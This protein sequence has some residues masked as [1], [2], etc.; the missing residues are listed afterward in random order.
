MSD[1]PG[2]FA[3]AEPFSHGGDGDRGVLVLHGFTGNPSSMRELAEAFASAGYHV[4][5]PRLPGPVSYTH[6][7]LP[8]ICSV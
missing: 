6:L 2:V 3:G 4:E 7:T 1:A 8:T 5:L